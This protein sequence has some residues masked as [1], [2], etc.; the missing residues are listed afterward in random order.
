M[1]PHFHSFPSLYIRSTYSMVCSPPM[2]RTGRA[3][4]GIKTCKRRKS[5][6]VTYSRRAAMT[7]L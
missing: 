3:W 6:A 5:L 7:F 2:W 1:M 4:R